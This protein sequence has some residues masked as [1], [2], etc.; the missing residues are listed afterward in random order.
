MDDV[1]MAD[2]F[3]LTILQRRSPARAIFM[4]AES[5]TPSRHHIASREETTT[6]LERGDCQMQKVREKRLTH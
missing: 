4:S 1:F 6:G 5:R 3:R 2:I